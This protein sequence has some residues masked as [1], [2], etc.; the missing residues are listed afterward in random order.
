MYMNPCFAQDD[1]F[2]II[3]SNTFILL[4]YEYTY[5]RSE[6]PFTPL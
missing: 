5:C 2:M 1:I 3:I 6:T 4:H